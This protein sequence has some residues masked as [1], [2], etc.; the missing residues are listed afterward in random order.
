MK[1]P[2][3]KHPISKKVVACVASIA[4]TLSMVPVSAIAFATPTEDGEPVVENSVVGEKAN[5]DN[6]TTTTQEET[7]KDKDTLT[8][9]VEKENVVE[10]EPDSE[11]GSESEEEASELEEGASEPEEVAVSGGVAQFSL[12]RTSAAAPRS[13]AVVEINGEGY[14]S[15]NEAITAVSST[16]SKTT[17][18]KLLSDSEESRV[19]VF[20][21]CNITLD[22]NGFEIKSSIINNGELVVK[23]TSVAQNGTI[24]S[25]IDQASALVNNGKT[26]I[27][28]GNFKITLSGQPCINNKGEMIIY[29]GTFYGYEKSNNAII[30]SGA[31]GKLTILNGD[32]VSN[33]VKG[34]NV[35]LGYGHATIKTVKGASTLI[36]N[37]R[38]T[39]EHTAT[40][41]EDDGSHLT[42]HGGTF[43]G[44][45]YSAVYVGTRTSLLDITG[46]TFIGGTAVV[47][48][49]GGNNLD[50]HHVIGG[51]Y[52]KTNGNPWLIFQQ[53]WL[54]TNIALQDDNGVVHSNIVAET[55]NKYF[56]S[57]KAAIDAA[58]DGDT[59][60]LLKDVTVD[61][62]YSSGASLE[63][64]KALTIDGQDHTI[65][66]AK[67]YGIRIF[68]VGED[69][70]TMRV[71]L[72]DITV[73]N[74]NGAGR[75][76]ETRGGN[77]EL[78]L[79]NATLITT[80]G[81]NTQVLTIGGSRAN[82]TN[83]TIKNGSKL[84]ASA[85]GYGV[86]TFNPV[87][88]TIDDSEISG[89]AALYFKDPS[90]SAGSA[91]SK[92]DIVNGAKVS[93][94]GLAGSSNT[95][96]TIVFQESDIN[97]NVKDAIVEVTADPNNNPET[98]QA[99][100]LFSSW[101]NPIN[102][103]VSI[104]GNSFVKM[105]NDNA[106]FVRNMDDQSEIAISGGSFTTDVNEYCVEGHGT[107]KPEGSEYYI[108]HKHEMS[109]PETTAATCSAE[110]KITSSCVV[111]GC[112]KE[113]T[114]AIAIDPDAH[115]WGEWVVTTPATEGVDGE[116]Q[117]VCTHDATHVETRA[118]DSLPV[119]TPE[120]PSTPNN[121]GTTTPSTPS[122]P[123]T[124][125]PNTPSN[126]G[127][128]TPNTPNN[129]ANPATIANPIAQPAAV[130]ANNA[131]DEA[132]ENIEDEATPLADNADEQ[133]IADTQNPLAQNV[134]SEG[135][136][137]QVGLGDDWALMAL[138]IASVAVLGGFFII[139]LARKRK[140]DEEEA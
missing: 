93:S 116:E 117:R 62:K 134:V 52:Q 85:A 27:Y 31:D 61:E 66:C 16:D 92:I 43:Q 99:A 6:N 45:N 123:G 71:I 22:L 79:D 41:V 35:T 89:Y 68:G 20:A 75:A 46:G 111:E 106:T 37:G 14:D 124:T 39:G 51:K 11:K 65:T 108:V 91:G 70:E 120:N 48:F 8:D 34:L 110:G 100:F 103:K 10:G 82:A 57:L 47:S 44:T 113:T 58:E 83:V 87:N 25:N 30:N 104:S 73:S 5:P 40:C 3:E 29:G 119:T 36:K 125:T 64:R 118:I 88:L 77:T 102:V 67:T 63:I 86:I 81:G 76:V 137:D 90:S 84:I 135:A 17:T 69:A 98:P 59:V 50:Y 122:N 38:F 9:T 24:V 54:D 128:T 13:S 115:A 126:P 114:E 72:K 136:S 131:A 26:T 12:N 2:I 55:G 15:L 18:I 23:D 53:K 132:T 42:I 56:S 112:S 109:D 97:V 130:N 32:F 107:A 78:V 96:G 129:N 127:N 7:T 19:T 121:P 94:T 80:G 21:G 133:T 4:M 33:Y 105:I 140:K 1:K 49:G 74:A 28:G 101:A 139:I 138:A 95:F 60:L